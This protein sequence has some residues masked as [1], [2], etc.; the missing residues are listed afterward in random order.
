MAHKELAMSP[1][2]IQNGIEPMEL[3]CSV[4]H[5]CER[6]VGMNKSEGKLREGLRRLNSLKREFLPKLTA[7]TPHYLTRCLE[8]RNIMDLAEVHIYACLERKETRGGFFRADY[9]QIDPLRTN[10]A[11]Y[12]RMEN[13][14]S[15][16]EIREVPDL[17]QENIEKGC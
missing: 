4:R 12:Q 6:Y 3:E 1:L 14:K 10:M 15:I 7:K 11:T 2:N 13:G 16:L 17:K 9:P 8:I 5:I